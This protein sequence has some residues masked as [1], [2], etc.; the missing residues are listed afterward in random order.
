MIRDKASVTDKPYNTNK[1]T[2]QKHVRLPPLGR[3]G[4]GIGRLGGWSVLFFYKRL[5]VTL[6]VLCRRMTL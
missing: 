6:C 1:A 3:V 4:V 5:H 2:G